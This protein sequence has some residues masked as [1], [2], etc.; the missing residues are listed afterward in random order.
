MERGK[1]NRR[2][3]GETFVLE[4]LSSSI[5]NT[6]HRELPAQRLQSLLE[7]LEGRGGEEED[8]S[9]GVNHGVVV[10][11]GVDAD[12][13]AANLD[14]IHVDSVQLVSITSEGSVL[15]G[16]SVQI[17]ISAT[18]SHDATGAISVEAESKLVLDLT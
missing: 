11:G 1:S 13:L 18:K 3:H 8:V 10:D 5:A 4:E 16:A 14:V 6:N 15:E 2:G 17:G 9:S 7:C 12:G